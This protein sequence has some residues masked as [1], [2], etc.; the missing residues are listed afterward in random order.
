MPSKSHSPDLRT[1]LARFL[2]EESQ[3]RLRMGPFWNDLSIDQKKLW[4]EDADRFKSS[5]ERCGLEI[6]EIDYKFTDEELERFKA[7]TT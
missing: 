2:C 5:M 3:W 6:S 4:L 7:K 1:K